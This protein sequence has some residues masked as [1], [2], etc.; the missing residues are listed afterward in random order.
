MSKSP[1]QSDQ[2][3]QFD[4]RQT[5]SDGIHSVFETML[6]ME[7]EVDSG[8]ARVADAD[9]GLQR[10]VGS[11]GIGGERVTGALYF[12][13]SSEFAREVAAI[14]LGMRLD[15]VK[16]ESEVNDVVG[17]LCNMVG[18]TLKSALCNSGVACA[19][20]TPCI[21]RGTSFAIEPLPDVRVERFAFI[22]QNHRV[23]A[24]VHINF[25]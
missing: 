11:V 10:V 16:T 23:A 12:H 14:M 21:I 3:A 2:A 5:V 17:E 20:S 22:C 8:N 24:E 15:E 7:I 6:G 13:L 19:M 9:L 18:G 1:P 25:N 4:V